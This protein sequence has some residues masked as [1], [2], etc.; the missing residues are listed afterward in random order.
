[1]HCQPKLASILLSQP[2]I[3]KIEKEI[4]VKPGYLYLNEIFI[5]PSQYK[6]EKEYPHGDVNEK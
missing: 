4:I 5:N 2:K 6:P 1:M 3:I